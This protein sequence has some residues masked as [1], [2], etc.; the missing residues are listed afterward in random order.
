MLSQLQRGRKCDIRVYTYAQG[1]TVLDYFGFDRRIDIEPA[2]NQITSLGLDPVSAPA[3]RLIEDIIKWQPDLIIIDGEPLVQQLLGVCYDERK[4]V[5]LLN[6]RDIDNDSLPYS[7]QRF[8]I[9]AFSRA[10]TAI[11]HGFDLSNRQERKYGQCRIF[12]TNTIIRPE[13]IAMK[14]I[15]GKRVVSCILGGGSKF[16]DTGFIDGT[17]NLGVA[18]IKIAA[19]TKDIKFRLFCNDQ[20]V[21]GRIKEFAVSDNVEICE[22]FGEPEQVYKDADIIVC[23]A[24]RNTISEVLYLDLPCIVVAVGRDYRAKEQISNIENIIKGY[25]NSVAYW[26]GDDIGSLQTKIHDALLVDKAENGFIPGN[27][28]ALRLINQLLGE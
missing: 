28:D 4:I 7:T 2:P 24:G 13:I 19:E 20:V 26:D 11:V 18:L 3:A 17:V 22:T 10:N 23:R 1:N 15:K 21:R 25:P 12:Y 16:A 9:E 8:F 6:P 27:E 14:P 5:A